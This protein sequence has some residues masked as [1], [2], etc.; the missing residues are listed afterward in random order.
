M[1]TTQTCENALFEPFVGI[2]TECKKL[3][4]SDAGDAI[5]GIYLMQTERSDGRAYYRQNKGGAFPGPYYVYS[6]CNKGGKAVG[7]PR[8]HIGSAQGSVSA[9]Y[10]AESSGTDPSTVDIGTWKRWNGKTWEHSIMT[11]SCDLTTAGASIPLDTTFDPLLESETQINS[12]DSL[13]SEYTGKWTDRSTFVISIVNTSNIGYYDEIL[14]QTCSPRPA[15]AMKSIDAPRIG[16]FF[17][18]IKPTAWLR[19]FPVTSGAVGHQNPMLGP[20]ALS[21]FLTGTYGMLFPQIA[22]VV[23]SDPVSTDGYGIGD[24]ITIFFNRP[25]NMASF[26]PCDSGST[27]SSTV[28]TWSNRYCCSKDICDAPVLTKQEINTIFTFSQ[29]LGNYTG[30]WILKG[31][32]FEIRIN[33]ATASYTSDETDGPPFV[34]GFVVWSIAKKDRF[35]MSADGTGVPSEMMSPVLEGSFGPAKVKVI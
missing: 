29:L 28:L 22:K 17:I 19:N 27:I 11:V 3:V 1:H 15:C 24:R 16:S 5:S 13:G 9:A 33:N 26:A 32:A 35:I 21:P 31:T 10:F 34:G 23:A 20:F 7:C 12:C 25:T 6:F 4:V 30:R 18:R 14:G 8:W 2:L